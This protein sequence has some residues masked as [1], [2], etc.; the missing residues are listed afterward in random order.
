MKK[1]FFLICAAIFTLNVAAQQFSHI[2]KLESSC[3]LQELAPWQQQTI[4]KAP[5]KTLEEGL[6]YMGAF[7]SDDYFEYGVGLPKYPGG[8]YTMMALLPKDYLVNYDGA[9]V[10]GLRA[11]F[12]G[13]FGAKSKMMLLGANLSDEGSLQYTVLAEGETEYEVCEGWNSVKFSQP[14]PVIDLEQYNHIGLAYTYM[15][16]GDSDNDNSYPIGFNNEGETRFETL[17]L[18]ALGGDTEEKL[19]DIGIANY[20]NLAIQAITKPVNFKEHAVTPLSAEDV[21]MQVGTKANAAV[22]VKNF[23]SKNVYNLSYVLYKDGKPVGGEKKVSIAEQIAMMAEAKIDVEVEAEAHNADVEYT[24]EITKVNDEEN[25]A[26]YNACMFTAHTMEKMFTKHVAVEE[27]TGLG[28][29]WCPRGMVGM[30]LMRE[31]FP[32][33][34]VGLGIHQYSS[35]D[36]M[37]IDTESYYKVGFTG[38]PSCTIDRDGNIIDPYYGSG[39]TVRGIFKNFQAAASEITPVDVDVTCEWADADKTKLHVTA[40]L[41][42]LTDAEY[43]LEFIA[44]GDNIHLEGDIMSTQMQSNYYYNRTDG[45]DL[46][47]FC[48]GGIYG[49]KK[50][51]LTFDDVVLGSSYAY[52]KNLQKNVTLTAGVK[53]ELSYDVLISDNEVLRTRGLDYEQ[54]AGVALVTSPASGKIVNCGKRYL[55]GTFSG[56]PTGI[57]EVK[58]NVNSDLNMYNLNG[59]RINGAQKGIVI[60]NGKKVIL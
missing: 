57:K 56:D 22:T 39:S 58:T 46:A 30:K 40:T 15:Q 28:C 59:Q 17:L 34:F 38:A 49:E 50:V 52:G 27:F 29:G 36:Y 42:S 7:T 44:I 1:V 8:P 47:D 37:Y 16:L 26:E 18:A 25:Q 33:T 51:A 4:K 13:M 53:K 21:F 10:L 24:I 48:E 32:E 31:Q 2:E 5:R 12:T 60:I 54:V 55:N 35:Y 6:M 20:G 43:G 11:A 9:E 19:Y 45:G 41:E 23:G 3:N 14:Y